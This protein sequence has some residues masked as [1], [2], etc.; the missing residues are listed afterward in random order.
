V[1]IVVVGSG[2][3]EHALAW[4]LAC[5]AGD[6]PRA[7]R[8]VVVVPGNPGIARF[9]KCR[10]ID[11]FA[12][13]LREG[14]MSVIVDEQP[15]FVVIGPESFID[16]GIV[17]ACLTWGMP[18]FGP[19]AGAAGLESSK[20]FM[21][22]VT[23]AAGV[24]TADF[25][26]VRDA[27]EADAFVEA[28]DG[29]VVVKA[30]GLAAGKGVVVCDDVD[31]AKK[32]VRSFLGKD[33]E[34]PRF[35]EAS[36]VV[37]VEDK[38]FGDELSVFAL[39]DGDDAVILGA[40]RD[41]KRLR[42]GD[43]GPNTGGM[44]AVGPLGE[45]EGVS[46]AF[47]ED[48]R[49][50]FFLPTLREMKARGV[51]FR[52]VLFAGLMVDEGAV[53]LLEYNVRFGDPEAEVLLTALDVDLAPLM[54]TVAEK[55]P[56]PAGLKFP[57]KQKAAAVVV[58]APGYP[59][60]PETGGPIAGIYAAER[61]VE[62]RVFCAGVARGSFGFVVDGGRVVAVTARG[63]TF[64]AALDRAYRAVDQLSFEGMQVRRDIGQSVRGRKSS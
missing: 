34:R 57:S 26:V 35:G 52:G 5:G 18:C 28:R 29:R 14:V 23:R 61:Q 3:R 41:H 63:P 39:C 56:L 46:E 7:D 49:R 38:V 31:T 36:K 13:R 1:K 30:D 42:D 45:A 11:G 43:E 54:L 47:L 9:F 25:V 10:A 21:K 40:A 20:A 27:A 22:E 50:R 17:D 62:A 33:G 44:G 8:E 32:E 55:K 53:T 15:D 4:R 48:V 37:V 58:A 6:R 19:T 16:Q 60:N 51:P 12:G 24:P 59:H 64:D 2:A